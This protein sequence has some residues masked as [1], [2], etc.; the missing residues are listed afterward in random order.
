VAESVLRAAAPDYPRAWLAVGDD[1]VTTDPYAAVAEPAL[2]AVEP[3][4]TDAPLSSAEQVALLAEARKA[5]RAQRYGAAVQL[6]TKLQRQPEFP[7]RAEAQELLGLTRERAGQAAQA[8]AE[9]EEYLR[10]YPHG[11]AAVRVRERLRILRAAAAA[12]RTGGISGAEQGDHGWQA[13][14][15]VSQLLRRDS[16]GTDLNGPLYAT[17]VQN[18]IFTDADLFVHRDGER[19]A[20]A[21]RTSFGYV[22]NLLPPQ[23]AGADNRARI[24]TAYIDLNDRVSGLH[25]RF[26]R[27]TLTTDGIFGIF[28]GLALAEQLASSW[29]VRGT[30][31]MPVENAG[32]GIESGRRFET[33]ALDFAPALGHWDTSAYLT[34]QSFDGIRDRQAVGA[35]VQ[36]ARP[37][38]SLVGYVDYDTGFHSLNALAL[39]GTVQLPYRWQLTADLERRNAPL[40]TTGN[41]LIGQSVASL[42]ELERS[43]SE[44][45]LFQLARDRTPTNS[46]YVVSAIKQLGE[47][48][49]VIL[50]V[51][52]FRLGDTPA[53]GGIEA[54]PG[55][56]ERDSAYQLQILGSSLLRSGDFNQLVL[57]EDRTASGLTRGAQ[58]IS[59]YPL[60]GAWRFGPRVLVQRTQSSHGLT[61][62]LYAPYGHLDYQRNGR[63][64]EMEAGAELGRN[65]AELQIGNSTRLFVSIGYRINF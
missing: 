17:L 26:G 53:S 31:G 54:F 14:G 47:R 21:F 64:L 35:Q 13:S 55:S 57:R 28:D 6:L 4:G 45:Q 18:A 19:F 65:P 48:W 12:V 23:I 36:Y 56:E 59:R 29:T 32:D 9:Y 20:T 62:N 37:A 42:T 5:E 2:P 10:R 1:S 3:M 16:Y 60:F 38:A 33:L 34:R 8:K 50:D 49:Q 39:L 27:Q 52:D 46:S 44:S 43:Y 51:F 30:F 61:Q 63:V 22:K 25:G 15:G 7:A 40:L 58:F 11:A 41:A 24:T